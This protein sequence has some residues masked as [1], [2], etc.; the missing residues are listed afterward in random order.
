VH[1]NLLYLNNKTR[2]SS[3]HNFLRFL[4]TLHLLNSYIYLG[5]LFAIHDLLS[6]SDHVSKQRTERL[7]VV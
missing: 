2:I 7:C 4:S 3:S 6:V 1:G 5:S